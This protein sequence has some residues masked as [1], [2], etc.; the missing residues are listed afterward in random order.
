MPLPYRDG[1]GL[2]EKLVEK[3]LVYLHEQ[4][5]GVKKIDVVAPGVLVIIDTENKFR[6]HFDTS[7]LKCERLDIG[8]VSSPE[9]FGILPAEEAVNSRTTA[10][11]AKDNLASLAD[12]KFYTKP[13][14]IYRP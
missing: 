12:V 9:T 5:V 14:L 11:F 3:T 2:T 4:Q 7:L 10:V 1:P 8:E 13:K 6:V